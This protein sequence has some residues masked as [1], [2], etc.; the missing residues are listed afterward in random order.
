MGPLCGCGWDGHSDCGLR[1]GY[2]CRRLR[3]GVH[4]GARLRVVWTNDRNGVIHRLLEDLEKR[5]GIKAD[6]ECHDE[7]RNECCHFARRQVVQLF[8]L[9]IG[10]RAEEHP[11]IEPEQI[12][13][14]EDD[15]GDGP[16][17]PSASFP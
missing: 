1:R 17:A 10:D 7:E 15:S 14:G 6:P 9:R 12:R 4:R 11:L 2:E 8:I 5:L 13:G 3:G 16:G